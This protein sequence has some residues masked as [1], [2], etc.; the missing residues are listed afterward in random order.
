MI[1]YALSNDRGDHTELGGRTAPSS[2]LPGSPDDTQTIN[3]LR[4]YSIEWLAN[5]IKA[6]VDG[7]RS[8]TGRTDTKIWL[9]R[10]SSHGNA[11]YM[12]IGRGL[13]R[14]TAEQFR[15]LADDYFVPHTEGGLGIELWGCNVASANT[16]NPA[17]YDVDLDGN[18]TL[19]SFSS[20]AFI[21]YQNY[22]FELS[23]ATDVRAC[24]RGSLYPSILRGARDRSGAIEEGH[25]YR[26]MAALAR[27]ANTKVTAAYDI[28]IP[29]MDGLDWEWE[30][31]GLLTVFPDGEYVTTPLI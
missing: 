10:I 4:N 21:A 7:F 28:Q 9:L 16:I 5:D 23:R 30:G 6:R 3:V 18:G 29:E 31:T 1:I 8:G 12:F 11:G 17:P 24:R 25:G 19:E 20:E 27:A 15:V 14:E 13:D 26:M 22:Q 2:S